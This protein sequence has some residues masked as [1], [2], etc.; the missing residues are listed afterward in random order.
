MQDAQVTK[1]LYLNLCSSISSTTETAEQ[2][3]VISPIWAG[4]RFT[5][6][7]RPGKVVCNMDTSIV[8]DYLN[9]L[10]TLSF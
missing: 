6:P 9:L 4:F 2:D 7:L 10:L 5:G 3:E 1:S 8:L